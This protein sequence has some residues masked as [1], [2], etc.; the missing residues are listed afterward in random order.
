M[1]VIKMNKSTAI[2]L[3]HFNVTQKEYEEISELLCLLAKCKTNLW[4]LEKVIPL[5]FTCSVLLLHLV[6]EN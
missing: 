6:T 2:A 3:I 1:I 4:R 5:V